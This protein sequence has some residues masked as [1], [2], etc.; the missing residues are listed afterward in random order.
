M[1]RAQRFDLSESGLYDRSLTEW[2]AEMNA[3]FVSDLEQRGLVHQV[4]A[5]ELRT[6][7]GSEPLT[8][9]IGFD[10]TAASL[11]VGSLLPALALARLQRAGH[12][13]IAL[14]GGGT[15]LIGDPSGKESERPMLTRERL[16]Q[17]LAG[18]RSQLEKFLDFEGPRGA[19][20]VDNADWLCSL[21]LIDFLRDVGK[22]FSVNAMVAKDSVRVRLESRDQGISFTE[23]SYSLLQAYD[24]QELYDRYGCRLQMGGSDQWGNIVAGADLI[25]RQ[26]GALAF[27]LTMP[28]MTRADGKKFGKSE[29]GNV[30][31]DPELTSPYELY[32]F[33]YNTEDSDV[34][35]YLKSFTF[36]PLA[37]IEELA[38]VAEAEPEKREAQRVLAGE[39]TRAVH[40]AAAVER[41]E[42]TAQVLFRG[43]DLASLSDQAVREAFAQAPSTAL[44]RAALGTAEAA[45]PAVLAASGLAPSK[46]QA[47]TAI[48]AGGVYLNNRRVADPGHVVGEADVLAGE[49][50]ILRRGKKSYH[51]LRL[52]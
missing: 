51:V 1:L 43:E 13:P 27:G 47:R 50:V 7:M 18:L 29:Q 5:P 26:R 12:R 22:H 3:S 20:L 14:V 42:H 37:E 40:G 48:A 8:A 19:V 32:Q 33:W 23:F 52:A 28:L 44:P 10:P 24:F 4:T 21:N 49:F 9:Y 39:V 11:H 17:N 25:R 6:L 2:P 35:R 45:L 34:V 46:A 30:W 15:G 36:M 31:L 41:A 38:R 16:A